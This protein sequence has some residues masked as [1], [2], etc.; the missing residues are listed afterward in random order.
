MY[1]LQHVLKH[2]YYYFFILR[3]DYIFRSAKYQSQL[4]N[5]HMCMAMHGICI[6]MYARSR[7]SM[8]I[9]SVHVYTIQSIARAYNVIAGF[10]VPVCTRVR[11]VF[12]LDRLARTSSTVR[13][14][15]TRVTFSRKFPVPFILK[16]TWMN[17]GRTV[18][19]IHCFLASLKGVVSVFQAHA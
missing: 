7:L 4:S 1:N 3:I 13:P 14:L 10:P 12:T 5:K 15:F 17:S 6:C 11:S 8:S 18:D 9:P 16:W 2:Y 19:D